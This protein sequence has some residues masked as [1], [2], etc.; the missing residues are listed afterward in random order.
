VALLPLHHH[1]RSVKER[2]PP[3]SKRKQPIKKTAS[4]TSAHPKSRN[5]Q[6]GSSSKTRKQPKT[7]KETPESRN[8]HQGKSRNFFI[9]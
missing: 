7:Q 5:P 3:G 2:Q 1:L 8:F 4:Q 9:L 6:K